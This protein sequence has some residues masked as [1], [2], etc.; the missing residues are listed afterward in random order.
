MIKIYHNPRCRKSREGLD[1][2]EKSG[3]EFEVI[4]YLEDVPTKEE[5]RQILSC[6]SISPENLVRKNEAIWKEKFRGK[7]LSDEEILEAMI[8]YP[9]LIERPIVVKGNKAVVGRPPERIQEVL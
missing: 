4:K 6:L 8:Q 9:K 5:L 3:K 1:L 2:L 7:L